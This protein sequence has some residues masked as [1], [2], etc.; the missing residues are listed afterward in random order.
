MQL[1]RSQACSYGGHGHVRAQD[2]DRYE[3]V[4]ALIRM[5]SEVLTEV[6]SVEQ[7][8]EILAKVARAPSLPPLPHSSLLPPP[9]LTAATLR[10]GR[11]RAEKRWVDRS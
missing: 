1:Q 3:G 8:E 4:A 11:Q 9:P 6:P 5:S 10:L 2:T 7:Q